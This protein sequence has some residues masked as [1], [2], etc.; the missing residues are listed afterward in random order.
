VSKS[1]CMSTHILKEVKTM[2]FV[3]R[4]KVALAFAL[5]GLPGLAA[6]QTK[7]A[8]QTPRPQQGIDR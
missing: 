3:L 4:A 2:S 6:A 1:H 7:P 8:G 5:L